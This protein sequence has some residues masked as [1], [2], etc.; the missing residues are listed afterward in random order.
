MYNVVKPGE[1]FMLVARNIQEAK[2]AVIH[3][4][5]V[6]G[7]ELLHACG[8]GDI[9]FASYII[10]TGVDVNDCPGSPLHAAV[11][12]NDI[13]MVKFLLDN[14]VDV[15]IV[16]NGD[17]PVMVAAKLK[18]VDM[19]CML[20]DNGAD[21]YIINHKGHDIF[22]ETHVVFHEYAVQEYIFKNK[23]QY[24]GDLVRVVDID[25]VLAETYK[26]LL[27]CNELAI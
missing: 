5:K 18:Y 20:L 10:S 2:E 8:N 16:Y 21:P 14:G 1:L 23:P 22:D 24:I 15:N 17:T 4:C 26:D 3:G 12:K 9:E 13:D 19:L 11:V 7:K 6:G 27:L 25:P